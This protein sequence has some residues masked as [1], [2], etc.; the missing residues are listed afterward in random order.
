MDKEGL[1]LKAIASVKLAKYD[2][3]GNLLSID[4]HTVELTEKEAQ[5]IW[6]SQK[7]V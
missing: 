2:E 6:L 3:Y 1:R 7:P 5:D 4:E